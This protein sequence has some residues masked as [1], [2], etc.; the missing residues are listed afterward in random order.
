MVSNAA[1]I[2]VPMGRRREVGNEIATFDCVIE[3]AGDRH[4]GDN[5]VLKTRFV[6]GESR[7]PV[8]GPGCGTSG[9]PHGVTRI[10]EGQRR[11]GCNKPSY[12]E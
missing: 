11:M 5:G 10:Q 2:L 12:D 8:V 4:V 3:C 7:N 9:A 1:N 6:G